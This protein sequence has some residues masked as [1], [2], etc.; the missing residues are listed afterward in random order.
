MPIKLLPMLFT[1]APFLSIDIEDFD[2]FSVTTAKRTSTPASAAIILTDSQSCSG[3]K[4]VNAIMQP[5]RRA[6]DVAS[7]FIPSAFISN[8]IP[9]RTLE[10][11]FTTLAKFFTTFAVLSSIFFI[12]FAD[13]LSIAPTPEKTLPKP[14]NGAASTSKLSLIFLTSMI[15]PILTPPANIPPQFMLPT[16]SAHSE[17]NDLMQFQA[18]EAN[19]L[20]PSI[21][22]KIKFT[23]S[24][25]VLVEGECMPRISLNFES[26]REPSSTMTCPAICIP[27]HIP[28]TKP[29]IIF[30]GTSLNPLEID[31]PIRLMNPVIICQTVLNPDIIPSAISFGRFSESFKLSIHSRIALTASFTPDV[32]FPNAFVKSK[33]DE[34]HL[35]NP[36]MASPTA[37][38]TS[39]ISKSNIPRI[40]LKT[41]NAI[42]IGPLTSVETI[43][44]AVNKPSKV[45]LNLLAVEPSSSASSLIL[46]TPSENLW[47]AAII[48]YRPCCFSSMLLG[49][50]TF[51]QASPTEVKAAPRPFAIFL[52]DS[53]ISVLPSNS[54]ILSINSCIGI[55][56]LSASFLTSLNA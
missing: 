52:K 24:D 7:F 26:I 51:F 9:F 25:R 56:S 17:A 49:G 1:L 10:K 14:L 20:R 15:S 33:V 4:N 42:F 39:R 21:N 8:A 2:I 22:P 32:M 44:M 50:N 11:L 23:P 3:L 16:I 18:L 41:L 30:P 37:A 38:V 12:G 40:F 5:T 19:N 55:P 47:K 46:F 13:A 35:S 45:R 48:L 53:I 36:T 54:S 28:P 29:E 27:F 6:I 43:L 31:S 34:I